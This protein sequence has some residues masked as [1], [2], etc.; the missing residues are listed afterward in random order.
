MGL[1]AV[2]GVWLSVS[3][4]LSPVQL[5]GVLISKS[6][7]SLALSKE[8]LVAEDKNL[9]CWSFKCLELVLAAFA[10]FRCIFFDGEC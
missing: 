1:V 4:S 10:T 3:A 8:A 7:A 9:I 5:S 2:L 6:S